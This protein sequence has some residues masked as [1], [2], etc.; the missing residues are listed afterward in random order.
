[1]NKLEFNKQKI[2]AAVCD[3]GSN[4]LRLFGRIE[5]SEASKELDEVDD[6]D[7]DQD[8]NDSEDEIDDDE[9]EF[10]NNDLIF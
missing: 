6:D 5:D 9:D 7:D 10:L 3:E 4:L 1:V 8:E 2:I